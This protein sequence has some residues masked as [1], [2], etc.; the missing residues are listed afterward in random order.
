VVPET[1]A[2]K[3]SRRPTA[4][5][6]TDT[7]A[8]CPVWDMNVVVDNRGGADARFADELA[9]GLRPRGFEVEVRPPSPASV[10]DTSVHVVDS[11][12]ALR[13][14]QRPD[15]AQLSEIEDAVRAALRHRPSVRRQTQSVP[16]YLGEGVRVIEW[17]D[18][19]G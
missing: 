13:I 7:R 14:P 2:A 17:I 5:S 6:L 16:L 3:G 18:A 9:T 11:A 12:V 8:Y 10:F 15:P 19:F 1:T 4:P